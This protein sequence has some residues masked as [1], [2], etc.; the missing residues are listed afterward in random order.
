MLDAFNGGDNGKDSIEEVS[1][2]LGSFFKFVCYL[3]SNKN[4]VVASNAMS[5]VNSLI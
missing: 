4:I 3:L 5:I 2:H 1:T